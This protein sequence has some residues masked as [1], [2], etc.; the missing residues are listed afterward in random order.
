MYKPDTYNSKN[1]DPHRYDDML[2]LPHHQSSVRP[3]MNGS[4]RAAQ[5]SPFAALTGYDDEIRETA[6]LTEDRIE[7][8]SNQKAE[9]DQKFQLIQKKLS[10]GEHPSCSFTCFV[11]DLLKSGGSYITIS[12]TVKKT[13]LYRKKIILYNENERS[14]GRE[15]DMENILA[16]EIL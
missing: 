12:G 3:H 16:M 9:L 1:N 2:D 13:D 10:E 11:P 6:R 5:F 7:L 15:V 4:D 8:D 14:D